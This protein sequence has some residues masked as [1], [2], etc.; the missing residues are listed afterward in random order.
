MRH[1]WKSPDYVT[2]VGR[3][4]AVVLF[5]TLGDVKPSTAT[6]L[7]D[8][9]HRHTVRAASDSDRASALSR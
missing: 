4:D 5:E 1:T 3:S 8:P 2:N 7:R 9:N 6:L